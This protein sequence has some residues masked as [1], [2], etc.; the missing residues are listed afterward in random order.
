MQNAES[1]IILALDT[2][3]L[4]V[5][6]SWVA[7]TNGTVGIYKLGLEFFLKFGRDGVQAIQNETDREIFLDLKLHDIPNTVGAATS[8]VVALKPRFLTVHATGGS[9]MIKAAVESAPDIQ[10]TAVTILTSLSQMDMQEIGFEGN[11]ESRAIALAKLAA[12]AGAKAIVCSPH[13]ISGIRSA[14]P[15]YVSIITPGIRPK[16][17]AG[18]DDQ[19]R[20]M[21]PRSALTAGANY[22]VI[23][24]P[25]TAAANISEAAKAILAES[26]G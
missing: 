25:I 17:T 23:G 20:V 2:P 16:A 11:P 22:L 15:N 12:T 8:Q 24:R 18:G 14:I 9:S 3:D 13:E 5:A 1:P 7:Q 6:K 10:I 4:E 19:K 26:L 21:D